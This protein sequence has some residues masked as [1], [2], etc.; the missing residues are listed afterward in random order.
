MSETTIRRWGN[1]Q[2]IRIPR[3]ILDA[4]SLKENETVTIEAGK[5]EIII[6]KAAN[7]RSI[8]ELFDGF[9]GEYSEKEADFGGPVGNEIW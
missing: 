1:S 8:K 3:H 6:R 9:D 4:A 5:G 2:G 7:R